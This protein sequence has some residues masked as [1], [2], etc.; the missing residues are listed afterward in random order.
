MD[1][2]WSEGNQGCNGGLMTQAMDYIIK[3]KGLDSEQSYP[4]SP[5]SSRDCRYKT[6]DKSST[7]ASYSNVKSGS[8]ADLQQAVNLS[9]TSIAID[10][11]QSSF[12]FY[13]SGVYYD[14]GC[15]S[16]AL[17]H[18]VLAVGWG[19]DAGKDYW[20]VKNSWGTSWGQQ[21][22]IWMSR[23]RNNNCGVATMATRPA[24]CAN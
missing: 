19:V 4:Y 5:V 20:I 15:S 13:Q 10:A 12:Q 3:N 21:G 2:S 24:N 7:L 11:S 23:N 14:S 1:C 6:A 17:D 8:E 18:G 9:P 16:S 22:Y